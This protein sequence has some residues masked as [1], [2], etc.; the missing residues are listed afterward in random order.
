MAGRAEQQGGLWME[1]LCEYW[2]KKL[3]RRRLQ[4]ASPV[5]LS[6]QRETGPDS[7][8]HRPQSAHGYRSTATVEVEPRPHSTTLL[9][10]FTSAQLL[11]K[12]L[13]APIALQKRG[14]LCSP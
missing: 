2:K 9:H 11:E 7:T 13:L 1:P 3:H 6:M 8:C 10:V 14:D 5:G 4:W 12:S